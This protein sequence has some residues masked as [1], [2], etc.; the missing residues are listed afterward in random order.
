MQQSS[1]QMT[2]TFDHFV[3]LLLENS[4]SYCVQ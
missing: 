4:R 2:N 3:L 1:T